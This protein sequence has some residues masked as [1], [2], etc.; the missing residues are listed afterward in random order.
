MTDDIRAALVELP[1][2]WIVDG[3]AVVDVYRDD[4]LVCRVSKYRGEGGLVRAA[5]A[6]RFTREVAQKLDD[7]GVTLGRYGGR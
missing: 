7:I 5:D 6:V 2:Q 3:G 1:G 4:H